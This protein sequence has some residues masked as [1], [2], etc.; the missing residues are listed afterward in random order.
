MRLFLHKDY[1]KRG[2]QVIVSIQDQFNLTP[3]CQ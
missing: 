3:E 1:K 2:R